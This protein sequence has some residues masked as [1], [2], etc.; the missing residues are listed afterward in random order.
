MLGEIDTLAKL[1][2]TFGPGV[3]MSVMAIAGALLYVRYWGKRHVSEGKS[4]END[5]KAHVV[6][7]EA[8]KAALTGGMEQLALRDARIDALTGQMLEL[9]AA[10]TRLTIENAEIRAA[11]DATLAAAEAERAFLVDRLDKTEAAHAEERRRL[12]DKINQMNRANGQLQAQWNANADRLSKVETEL[13]QYRAQHERAERE[14]GQ[15]KATVAELQSERGALQKRVTDQDSE[16]AA[17]KEKVAHLRAEL[18][19]M[20]SAETAIIE[21]ANGSSDDVTVYT[22]KTGDTGKLNHEKTDTATDPNDG[23]AIRLPAS[24]GT[25]ADGNPG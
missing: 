11:K 20:Y 24:T 13:E 22:K 21:H 3:V 17:L 23:A 15:L 2:E 8:V 16:I 12:E 9:S 6:S 19:N 4:E 5:T 18:E 25:G 1:L 14:N 10:Q 7:V